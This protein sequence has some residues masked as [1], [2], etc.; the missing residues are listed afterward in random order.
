MSNDGPCTWHSPLS[1][2][3]GI[4]H[5]IAASLSGTRHELILLHGNG[6]RSVM[7]AA[8]DVLTPAEVARVAKLLGQREIPAVALYQR[9]T[10]TE[11]HL[12]LDGPADQP[13]RI[14]AVGLSA[15]R[16]Q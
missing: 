11:H 6:R 12:A 7:V 9:S 4:A 3:R 8:K 10:A 14:A 16:P 1:E 5:R 2:F 15:A 13:W